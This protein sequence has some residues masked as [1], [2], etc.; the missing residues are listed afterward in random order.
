MLEESNFEVNPIEV[1]KFQLKCQ[2]ELHKMKMK[3]LEYIRESD[4]LHHEREMERQRIKTAEIRKQ[5]ERR[6]SL[7]FMRK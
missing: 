5:M 2:K 6:E 1:M 4:I 7:D 3:E